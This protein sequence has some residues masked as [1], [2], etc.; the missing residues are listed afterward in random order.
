MTPRQVN[1]TGATSTRS[2]VRR[3]TPV[4]HSNNVTIQRISDDGINGSVD[5]LN[6]TAT[7]WNGLTITNSTIQ[8][9]N[10]FNVSG[11]AERAG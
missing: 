11:H 7:V 10:R 1:D 2:M 8:D 4:W 6:P 3:S 5:G 9:T